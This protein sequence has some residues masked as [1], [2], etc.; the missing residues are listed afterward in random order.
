M[1]SQFLAILYLAKLQ[2][3]IRHNLHLRFVNYMDDYIIIHHNKDYLLQC[4][5]YIKK[6]LYN[7][8]KLE[9]NDKK[10]YII[11]AKCGIPFLGYSYYKKIFK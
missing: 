9:I 10:T 1:T 2:H 8:Y 4:L 7:E 11:N 5:E 6:I 3:Y